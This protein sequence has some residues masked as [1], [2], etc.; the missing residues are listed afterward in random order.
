[1]ADD[2]TANAA[3]EANEA[4]AMLPLADLPPGS[5]KQVHVDGEAVCL[6]NVDGEVYAVSDTCTH[7][8]VPLSGGSL[9]GRQIVC[10]WHMAMF[11]LKTGRATCGPAVHPLRVYN[12]KVEGE[13][14]IVTAKSD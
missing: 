5:V 1:M 13:R 4:M 12:V 11:D 9:A 3:K 7:A 14:I 6:A 8:R 2:Q 10:P